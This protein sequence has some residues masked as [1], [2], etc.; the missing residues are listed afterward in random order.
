MIKKSWLKEEDRIAIN[1]ISKI[2]NQKFKHQFQKKLKC[3]LDRN[4]EKLENKFRIRFL[5]IINRILA[6]LMKEFSLSLFVNHLTI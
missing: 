3:D 5:E 6:E 1:A 2:Y 4:I